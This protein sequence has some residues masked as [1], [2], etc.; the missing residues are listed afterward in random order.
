MNSREEKRIYRRKM[1]IHVAE[2]LKGRLIAIIIECL[3]LYFLTN[4]IHHETK[5]EIKLLRQ[6]MT[7]FLLIRFLTTNTVF[8][9]IRM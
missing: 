6:F 8:F 2:S 4:V 7:R 5:I 9:H 1:P 3:A